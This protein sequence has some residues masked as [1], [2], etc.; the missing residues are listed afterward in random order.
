[1]KRRDLGTIAPGFLEARVR[2]LELHAIEP[3]AMGGAGVDRDTGGRHEGP[4][5]HGGASRATDRRRDVNGVGHAVPLSSPA[6]PVAPLPD[7]A[8]DE[9]PAPVPIDLPDAA[10]VP[11]PDPSSL[12][13]KSPAFEELCAQLAPA[14]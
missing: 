10:L 12:P 7:P 11:P 8:P 6:V 3:G 13:E 5:Q 1:L 14:P 2:A 9:L 4:H